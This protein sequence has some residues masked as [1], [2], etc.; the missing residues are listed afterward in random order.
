LI[1]NPIHISQ[2]GS[3]ARS[4]HLDGLIA[5]VTTLSDIVQRVA[6][7]VGHLKEYSVEIRARAAEPHDA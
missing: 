2:Y 5:Q 3:Q 1:I 6:V 4:L 7:D